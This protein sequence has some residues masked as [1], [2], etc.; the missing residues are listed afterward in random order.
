MPT[1]TYVRL[2]CPECGK[3]WTASPGDLPTPGTTY[4]CPGCH[5]SRRLSEFA[6]TEHEL[7]T[8]KTFG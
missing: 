4:H 1:E 7:E 6:R 8:L 2:L 3:Q 5:A